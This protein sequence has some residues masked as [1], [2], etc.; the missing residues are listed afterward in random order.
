ML[1]HLSIYFI[2]FSNVFQIIFPLRSP[3]YH[4]PSTRS[5]C[6]FEVFNFNCFGSRGWSNKSCEDVCHILYI[7]THMRLYKKERPSARLLFNVDPEAILRDILSTTTPVCNPYV[8]KNRF[9][10]TFSY[11]IKY[12]YSTKIDTTGFQLSLLM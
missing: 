10:R 1:T 8:G 9:Y 3:K 11:K 4:D 7:P 5:L 12:Y 6:P 2:L